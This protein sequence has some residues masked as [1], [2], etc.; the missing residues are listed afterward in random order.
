M[1]VK[2]ISCAYLKYAKK[3]VISKYYIIILTGRA[4]IVLDKERNFVK[5]LDG[6][7]YSYEGLLSP[8]ETKLLIISNEP[9]FYIF[10]LDTLEITDHCKL[11]GYIST[12]EGQGC[13]SPNGKDIFLIL[14]DKRTESFFLRIY[15]TENLKK[16]TDNYSIGHMIRFYNIL[17][18]PSKNVIYILAQSRYDE[19]TDSN[20][21]SLVLLCLKGNQVEQYDISGQSD[22]PFS[23]EYNETTNRFLIYTLNQ[24]FT[25][26]LDGGNV[27]MIDTGNQ[28]LAPIQHIFSMP[29][30]VKQIL[31]SAN[32]KYIFMASNGGLDIFD[33]QTGASLYFK[34]FS[35]G[36]VNITEIEE[37][38]IAVGMYSGRA[39]LY[40]IL[41]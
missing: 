2:Q 27:R 16:F 11:S 37:N 9:D 35:F 3:I 5:R 6:L 31:E 28:S 17:S 38:V 33:K 18:L 12:I 13:W 26:D 8:D 15:P 4:I 30:I 14:I 25:C 34:E 21:T 40:K 20:P 19:W 41:D 1:D 7:R 24:A 22:I 36:L 10:S 39:Q 32:N 23:I 29:F